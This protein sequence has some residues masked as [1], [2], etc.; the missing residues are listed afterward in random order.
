[1]AERQRGHAQAGLRDRQ[2]LQ[3]PGIRLVPHHESGRLPGTRGTR[4]AALRRAFRPFLCRGGHGPAS[5]RRRAGLYG[6]RAR[7]SPAHAFLHALLPLLLQHRCH[8][9]GSG[10]CI[11]ERHGHC[12]RRLRRA[13]LRLQRPCGPHHTRPCRT[14]PHRYGYGRESAHL[15][16]PFRPWRP[17]PYLHRRP[18]AQPAGR[19]SPRSGGN[20]G[21]YRQLSGHGG[22]RRED[23]AGGPTPCRALRRGRPHH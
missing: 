15:H 14:G 16:G 5:H 8:R 3:R 7:R 23:G 17:H 18:F 10:R 9:R 2:R 12:R 11:E 19:P 22:R 1:M 20:A 13:G 4:H 21:A 6:R